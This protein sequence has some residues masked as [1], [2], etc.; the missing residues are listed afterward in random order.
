MDR[1]HPILNSLSEAAQKTYKG[2]KRSDLKNSDFLFPETRS[3]PIVTPQDV[4][5]A[6]SNFGRMKG[7]MSYDAFLSK[8]YTFVKRKGP[9]FVAA[10]PE[11]TKEKLGVKKKVTANELSRIFKLGDKVRN[12]NTSCM[13]YGSEGIVKAFHELPHDMG[14]VVDYETTNSGDTWSKGERLKKTESQLQKIDPAEMDHEGPGIESKIA[15]PS[16]PTDDS[17]VVQMDYAVKPDVVMPN[18][19]DP[20][21]TPPQADDIED[22]QEKMEIYGMAVSSLR[23]IMEDVTMILGVIDEPDVKNRLTAGWLQGKIAIASD[24]VGTI[25]D[26]LMFTPSNDDEESEAGNQPGLWENIRKKRERMGRKY[27]PAKPGEKDRP[28]P[29]QW[30]KLTKD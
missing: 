6:I 4:P 2:Q 5:D 30:K 21:D 27:R 26:F 7:Q 25:R 29:E 24:Y 23:A 1:F 8:L 3:F 10:L 28:D 15:V 16:L 12:T 18:T 9:A 22:E 20:F 11:A 13:H 14:C 17:E 19:L